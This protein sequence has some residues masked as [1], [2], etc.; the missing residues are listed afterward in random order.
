VR[1]RELHDR[2]AERPFRS[3]RGQGRQLGRSAVRLRHHGTALRLR[4]ARRTGPRGSLPRAR[5]ATPRPRIGLPAPG[6]ARCRRRSTLLPPEKASLRS[7]PNRSRVLASTRSASRRGDLAASCCHRAGARRRDSCGDDRN[8]ITGL[9]R[10]CGGES[11]SWMRSTSSRVRP[12]TLG[13][14]AAGRDRQRGDTGRTRAIEWR[15]RRR[16]RARRGASAAGPAHVRAACRSARRSGTR[17]RASSSRGRS[18]PPT[19][20]RRRCFR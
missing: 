15:A 18:Q 10:W 7:S 16:A 20:R 3:R 13:I 19:A 14:S 4:P 17:R 9:A 5:P 2:E 8:V 11:L 12:R 6:R 1:L